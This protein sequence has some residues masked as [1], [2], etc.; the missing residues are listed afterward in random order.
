MSDEPIL[1]SAAMI[2]AIF[3]DRKRMTRRILKLPTRVN[4]HAIYERKDMGGWAPT[5]I[6]GGGC[7]AFVKGERVSVPETVGIWHQTCGVCITAPYQVGDSLWVRENWR[8]FAS[9]DAVKPSDI[10]TPDCG[11]G[12]G[13]FYEADGGGLSIDKAGERC[14]TVGVRED[15]AAFGKLRPSMFMP[16]CFSRLTLTCTDVRV[17]RLQDISDEDV[18]A[19]GMPADVANSPRVWYMALW[20]SLHGAGA[21]EANP[22]VSVTSFERVK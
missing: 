3:A 5:T 11:R 14:M 1:F 18:R 10:W 9:L 15:R 2:G 19:E 20:N 13:I 7:F 6:G 12:A 17:E 4:G 16:R 22:F 21:W 8:T